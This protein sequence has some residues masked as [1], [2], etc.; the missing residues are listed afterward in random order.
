MR[1]IGRII[2]FR[3]PVYA[4]VFAIQKHGIGLKTHGGERSVL[5]QPGNEN[6]PHFGKAVVAP[7]IQNDRLGKIGRIKQVGAK[8]TVASVLISCIQV[9]AL[10]IHSAARVAVNAQTAPPYIC[11]QDEPAAHREAH[12]RP[13][14]TERPRTY[15]SAWHAHFPAAL[16]PQ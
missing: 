13:F 9:E 7:G 16:H 10:G 3:N 2:F 15:P 14:R 4:P 11:P 6:I 5:C 1:Q 8:E 12:R